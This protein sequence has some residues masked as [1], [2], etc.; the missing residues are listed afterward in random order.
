MP[1]EENLYRRGAVWWLRATIG[2]VERRESLRTSDVRVARRLR[3]AR[4]EEISG[5]V[6]RG[7]P[8]VYWGDAVAAWLA[9][10]RGQIA[11][12][13]LI[14]YKVSLKQCET[15][16]LPFDVK[17]IDGKRL[18]ALVTARRAAGASPATIR[19]DL[20][21]ISRVLEFCEAQGW[22]EGNP[23]LSYRRHLKER[24]DPITLPEPAD[25]EWL[26][27]HCSARFAALIRA[28]E[29]TGCRQNELVTLRRRQYNRA[30]KTLEVIGKGNKRRTLQLDDAASAHLTAQPATLGS[31]LVFCREGGRAFAEAASDFTHV[32]RAAAAAAKRQG[33]PFHRFRFHDLRHLFAVTA[34][35][36]GMDIYTLSKHLGHTSVKTTEIYLA[37]LTPQQ[38]DKAKKGVARA[39]GT[40]P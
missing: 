31:E 11:D 16:L 33:R 14:R 39:E 1:D 24:R 40:S 19:R 3:D 22:R 4:L 34:L 23:T 6:R 20:T 26:L 38:T 2:G 10:A 29:L 15:E 7:E 21:A 17:A 36:G 25:L 30:A 37:F 12:T 8:T 28:A 5:A 35:R 32:R 13:T 27:K 9:E 18:A